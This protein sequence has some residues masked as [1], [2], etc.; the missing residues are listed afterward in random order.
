MV[1]VIMPITYLYIYLGLPFCFSVITTKAP[2]LI[3]AKFGWLRNFTFLVLEATYF[4][5][6]DTGRIVGVGTVCHLLED[7]QLPFT[8][9]NRHNNYLFPKTKIIILINLSLYTWKLIMWL[10]VFFYFC[11]SSLKLLLDVNQQKYSS[12][13]VIIT[14]RA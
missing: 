6:I 1:T 13:V 8:K 3:L 2:L 11:T 10:I 4:H 9:I 14:F 7:I 5:P 12:F